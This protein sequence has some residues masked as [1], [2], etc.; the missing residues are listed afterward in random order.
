M[1]TYRTLTP[2]GDALMVQLQAIYLKPL[3]EDVQLGEVEVRGL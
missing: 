1:G 3:D 2:Y